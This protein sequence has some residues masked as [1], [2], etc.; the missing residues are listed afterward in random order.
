LFSLNSF[1]LFYFVLPQSPGRAVGRIAEP[2]HHQSDAAAS[3]LRIWLREIGKLKSART[4]GS[5]TT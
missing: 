1:I 3:K 4:G 2:I 5:V